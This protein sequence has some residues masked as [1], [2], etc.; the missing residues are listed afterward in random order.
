MT[1][2]FT[3]SDDLSGATFTQVELRGARFD[4]C[5]LADAVV[6]GGDASGM[7]I[8]DPLL[9]DEEGALLVNG[10]NVLPFVDAELNRRFPGRE[11]RRAQT[12]DEFRSAWAA[13]ENTW[14]STLGRAA[15][16][17]EGAVNAS[18]DGEW[19]FA[20]T[21]RHL[22]MAID[23]W[24]GKA[25]LRRERPYHPIGQPNIEYELD[26]NDPSVFAAG[27]PNPLMVDRLNGGTGH[28]P[29][30]DE[31]GRRLHPSNCRTAGTVNGHARASRGSEFAWTR[32]IG[33]LSSRAPVG[34]HDCTL[35]GMTDRTNVRPPAMS[36]SCHAHSS[37]G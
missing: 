30:R 3:R 7:E 35:G 1:K 4:G 15:N 25:V 28:G 16:L 24:L 11:L 17:P 20:Q 9:L 36:A 2:S 33:R 26:G 12:P 6:R 8:D 23:T 29:R 32:R 21:L 5:T 22:V 31:L 27:H 10:V 18:I 34:D 19:S 13:V 37:S 14:A